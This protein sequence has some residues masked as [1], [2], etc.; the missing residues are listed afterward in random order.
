MIVSNN[1][2][3]LSGKI[4]IESRIF[5]LISIWNNEKNGNTHLELYLIIR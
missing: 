5:Y 2:V 1:T 3:D 4:K